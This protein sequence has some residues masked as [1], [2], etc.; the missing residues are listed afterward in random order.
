MNWLLWSQA[1]LEEVL[2]FRVWNS[3]VSLWH[4]TIYDDDLD[5]CQ[6]CSWPRKLTTNH[7]E[8]WLTSIVDSSIVKQRFPNSTQKLWV[9]VQ[10]KND[11]EFQIVPS[12][13][14]LHYIPFFTSAYKSSGQEDFPMAV[15]LTEPLEKFIQQLVGGWEIWSSDIQKQFRRKFFIW[16]LGWLKNLC[17]VSASLLPPKHFHRTPK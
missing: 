2:N 9:Q 4:P 5:A 3:S 7:E 6:K 8:H 1:G 11:R 15:K 14:I 16:T 10:A 12:S 17:K 13:S